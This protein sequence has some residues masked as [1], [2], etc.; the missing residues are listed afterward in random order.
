[1]WR[2][3]C[4][5]PLALIYLVFDYDLSYIDIN[6]GG[7]VWFLFKKLFISDSK[8]EFK[9]GKNHV[10]PFKMDPIIFKFWCT[11][12][13]IRILNTEM[14]N[15]IKLK[16]IYYVF[17]SLWVF[18]FMHLP[19]RLLPIHFQCRYFYCFLGDTCFISVDIYLWFTFEVN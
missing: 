10:A 8:F 4:V 6:G 17:I 13:S 2:S 15:K 9:N 19:F 12:I 14:R 18:S 16:N 5:L 7:M 1:M 3:Q 11:Q